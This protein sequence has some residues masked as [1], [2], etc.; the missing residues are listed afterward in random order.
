M[1]NDSTLISEIRAYIYQLDIFNV[2]S[3]IV[4]EEM[5]SSLADNWRVN[6]KSDRYL[7]FSAESFEISSAEMDCDNRALNA[8]RRL[9]LLIDISNQLA[10]AF[11]EETSNGLDRGTNL[12]HGYLIMTIKD[13][14]IQLMVKEA[15]KHYN[16]GIRYGLYFDVDN[17]IEAF[18][19]FIP[20]C[21]TVR[22]HVKNS[23]V[24]SNLHQLI[25]SM[26]TYYN[27]ENTMY[28]GRYG[29]TEYANFEVLMGNTP[30]SY[31]REEEK[32]WNDT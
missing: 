21:G 17:G 29:T 31:L 23:R 5:L 28:M 10:H 3:F 14:L 18:G 32:L 13:L 27:L 11:L 2:N 4:I 26:K 7:T 8:I 9:A 24:A 22:W 30:L 19:T 6:K 25:S 1:T 15:S 20:E 16:N 12:K